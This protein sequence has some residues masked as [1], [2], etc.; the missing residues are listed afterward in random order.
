MAHELANWREQLNITKAKRLCRN[1]TEDKYSVAILACGGMLDTLAAIRAGLMPIWGSD[2]NEISRQMW[3]NLVGNKCYGDAFG[4]NYKTIRRPTILKTGFPCTDYTKI[5]SNQGIE[6]ENGWQY[7]KQ[8]KIIKQ[9]SPDIAV[10]EQTDSVT[11]YP[12]EVKLL[13]DDLSTDYI[14]H[15][16]NIPVWVHGDASNRRR[17]FI[18]AVHKRLGNAAHTYQFPKATYNS[19]HYHIAADIAV[20]DDQVPPAYI[21]HG[22]PTE[23]YPWNEPRPGQIHHIGNYGEG[24]GHCHNP[25]PLH[26]W[27][28]L[29][30]TQLT[31][32]GGARRVMLNWRWGLPIHKTRLTV[33]LETVRMASLSDTYLNWAK[34]FDDSD[35]FLRR[36][37]N[38]GVPLRTGTAI[39]QSIYST[40]TQ[41]SWDK[42]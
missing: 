26:S 19:Q 5:G 39:D 3:A 41:T 25:H 37:V 11:E 21:L 34:S 22:Q 14:I 35:E 8:S 30:N 6:G 24:I 13:T 16:S 12:G 32:N 7:V 20:P 18:V 33:P 31:S 17:F 23:I 36:C 40:N 1:S 28:G 4:I 10:I 38:N 29:A 42:T 27:W 15:Q 2:T 9:I